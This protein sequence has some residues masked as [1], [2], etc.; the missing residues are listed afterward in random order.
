M[1]LYKFSTTKLQR[2]T[3]VPKQYLPLTSLEN[4][5]ALAEFVCC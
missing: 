2:G 4:M 1:V 5:E 3:T